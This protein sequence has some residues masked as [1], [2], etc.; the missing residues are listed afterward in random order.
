M[1]FSVKRPAPARKGS[2][3]SP[4]IACM[5]FFLAHSS[6]KAETDLSKTKKPPLT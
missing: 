2:V 3:C 6:S 4:P 5:T 1:F